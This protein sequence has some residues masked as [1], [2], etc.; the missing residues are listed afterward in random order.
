MTILTDSIY[1]DHLAQDFHNWEPEVGLNVMAAF[2]TVHQKCL[3]NAT[4]MVTTQIWLMT[5]PTAPGM[6]HILLPLSQW[7][8]YVIAM[9]MQTE[10]HYMQSTYI[11][12]TLTVTF[13]MII[14]V[15]KYISKI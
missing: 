10:E 13:L 14:D 7:V 11:I 8:N 5:Q 6:Y 9:V 4:T 1:K 2:N 3:K 15:S 12:V